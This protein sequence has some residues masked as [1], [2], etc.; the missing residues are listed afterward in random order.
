MVHCTSHRGESEDEHEAGPTRAPA[1]AEAFDLSRF[2]GSASPCTAPSEARRVIY[3]RQAY[4]M[5]VII[6]KGNDGQVIR[7][8]NVESGQRCAI[9][10]LPRRYNQEDGMSE[11]DYMKRVQSKHVV[12]VD[13]IFRRG[14]MDH[15]VMELA[16]MDLL[17]LVNALGSIDED[18]ARHFFRH[19]V[20]GVDACHRGGVA[21]LDIKPDNL[22]IIDD[23]T[24]NGRIK[25]T[26]FGLSALWRG[27]NGPVML[28]KACGSNGYAS[29]EILKGT[30]PYD[31]CRADVWSC[32][33][34]LY[35]CTQGQLPW[36][37]ACEECL[38]Y[39]W[40]TQGKFEYPSNMSAGLVA[41]LS[42]ILVS[43]PNRR[44][45]IE[46]IQQ[47][48]WFR[49]GLSESNSDSDEER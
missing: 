14:D 39:L 27:A 45:T 31:G 32:G 41:L 21:H 25:L 24:R 44:A 26:D 15:I 19:L 6:G 38:E 37:D 49:G 46:D 4:E 33:V 2:D 28:C 3:G 5:G 12:K 42:K 7:A 22:V 23:G 9:K 36:D 29:P 16:E 30:E 1:E 18:V 10:I 20:H 11:A 43:D 35:A 40:F 17:E 8:K 48:E 47:D 34:V 13:E